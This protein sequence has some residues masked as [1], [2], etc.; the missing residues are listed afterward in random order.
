M[1]P[2]SVINNNP[3]YQDNNSGY[4]VLDVTDPFSPAYCFWGWDGDYGFRPG[5][6]I[7]PEDYALRYNTGAVLPFEYLNQDVQDAIIALEDEDFIGSRH[8][9]DEAWSN[10]SPPLSEM[11]E[12]E[13]SRDAKEFIRALQAVAKSGSTEEAQQMAD[14][15]LPTSGVV[16][17]LRRTLRS[18]RLRKRCDPVII[19]GFLIA[20]GL[21]NSDEL[22][23][24]WM[25]LS[26]AQV[27]K[28][29]RAVL[30]DDS[31]KISSL[32]ISG[33]SDITVCT[34]SEVFKLREASEIK[35]L[36]LF[37]CSM[38]EDVRRAD[39]ARRIGMDEG[40]KVFNSYFPADISEFRPWMTK[41]R[42]SKPRPRV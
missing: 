22:D 32:D 15:L 19:K 39:M 26:P 1:S 10:W 24:S 13:A 4:T 30:Q 31:F 14:S 38:V 29:V 21:S 18:E 6:P 2:L 27:L 35:R 16:E 3:W 17:G 41:P 12:E 42:S 8:L 34:L 28:V 11:D 9:L 36:Y 5:Y 7:E 25:Q 23:L 37:G 40:G 33:N 20:Q